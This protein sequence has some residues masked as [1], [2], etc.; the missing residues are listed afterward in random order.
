MDT[1]VIGGILKNNGLQPA[2]RQE[3]LHVWPSEDFSLTNLMIN[4]HTSYIIVVQCLN[5]ATG[6][7]PTERENC[8]HCKHF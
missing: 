1:T 6:K 8:P 3:E 5:T 4:K 2:A 7:Y